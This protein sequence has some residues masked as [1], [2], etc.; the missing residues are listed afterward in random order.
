MTM[1][2]KMPIPP[3]TQSDPLD[4]LAK[5]LDFVCEVCRPVPLPPWTQ[6]GA[7]KP[8]AVIAAEQ[9][10]RHWEAIWEGQAIFCRSTAHCEHLRCRRRRRC[11]R[12]Q[13]VAARLAVARARLAAESAIWKPPPPPA[14]PPAPP[15]RGR[16]KKA[17]P[18]APLNTHPS[19]RPPPG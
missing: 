3:T 14:K 7:L 11:I 18:S 16:R 10:V 8:R 4:E 9:D 5:W 6:C 1:N 2:R 17:H 12:L 19:P 13:A 15:P